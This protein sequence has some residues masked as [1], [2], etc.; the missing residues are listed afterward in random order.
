[1]GC[2]KAQKAVTNNECEFFIGKIYKFDLST[3]YGNICVG[4]ICGPETFAEEIQLKRFY[5]RF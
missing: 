1:M 2:A 4:N 3:L 5:K